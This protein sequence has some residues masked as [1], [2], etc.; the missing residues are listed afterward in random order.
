MLITSPKPKQKQYNILYSL[1]P[2]SMSNNIADG[3]QASPN[4]DLF[5][6]LSY[7]NGK[8]NL[9][10]TPDQK[11]AVSTKSLVCSNKLSIVMADYYPNKVQKRNNIV[12]SKIK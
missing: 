4:A 2:R 12:V 7:Y 8:E 9:E 1:S 6:V 5:L 10:D 11:V 3:M